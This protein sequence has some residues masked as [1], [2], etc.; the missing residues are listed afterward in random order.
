LIEVGRPLFV[1]SLHNWYS[2]KKEGQEPLNE[3]IKFGLGKLTLQNYPKELMEIDFLAFFSL[4][5]GIDVKSEHLGHLLVETRMANCSYISDDRSYSEVRYLPEP[6]LAE[7]AA[8]CLQIDYEKK[9][10]QFLLKYLNSF[11]TAKGILGETIFGIL[12]LRAVDLAILKRYP[13]VFVDG[14][15]AFLFCRPIKVSDLLQKLSS[16]FNEAL[17]KN[18]E[19]F[20][21]KEKLKNILESTLAFNNI[22]QFMHQ[23]SREA[24][25]DMNT[26]ASVMW[27]SNNQDAFDFIIPVKKGSLDYCIPI[28]VKNYSNFTFSTFNAIIEK[29]KRSLPKILPPKTSTIF[30]VVNI[31][32]N[33]VKDVPDF[34]P[35]FDSKRIPHY[36]MLLTLGKQSSTESSSTSFPSFPTSCRE[37]IENLRS[38]CYRDVNSTLGNTYKEVMSSFSKTEIAEI[39]RYLT[40]RQQFE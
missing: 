10:L 28:Q 34:I 8:H 6:L 1:T 20:H 31:G 39:N 2:E 5:L 11:A 30:I 18:L 21:F 38:L 14:C 24:I 3:F 26:T 36:A 22:T 13:N 37:Y 16:T 7:G 4:R 35:F 9:L 12:L 40:G 17:E 23:I 19:E 29:S 25:C 27:A 15:P 33:N 32:P